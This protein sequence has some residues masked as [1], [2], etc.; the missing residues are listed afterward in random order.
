MGKLLADAGLK[1]ADKDN[2]SRDE[3]LRELRG[4]GQLKSYEPP[5]SNRAMELL[6]DEFRP[7]EACKKGDEF[8]RLFAELVHTHNALVT[9]ELVH[10]V[11]QLLHHLRD[12]TGGSR[13]KSYDKVIPSFLEIK[14]RLE[15]KE[16]GSAVVSSVTNATKEWLPPFWEK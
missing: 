15:K 11:S 6:P 9:K 5:Y 7:L 8:R 16:N 10:G 3:L 1:G 13:R 12:S 4:M 2:K 14:N